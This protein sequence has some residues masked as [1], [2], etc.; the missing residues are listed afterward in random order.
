MENYDWTEFL[1]REFLYRYPLEWRHSNSIY[2]Y[3][4]WT[5]FASNPDSW[6]RTFLNEIW[7]QQP[8]F[9]EKLARIGNRRVF[10]SHRKDDVAEAKNVAS[11]AKGAGW[12]YWLDVEDPALNLATA[13]LSGTPQ[14]AIAVA[15][16]IEFALLNCTHVISIL[17]PNT[18][19]STWVPYEYGRIKPKTFSTTTAICRSYLGHSVTGMPEYYY[20]NPI[21]LDDDELEKLLQQL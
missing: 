8:S 14:Y 6:R 3:E 16:I 18:K 12:N 7:P 11:I 2:G 1:D 20:L 15:G 17:T 21:C 10:I 4:F 13:I 19:G 5:L 9:D